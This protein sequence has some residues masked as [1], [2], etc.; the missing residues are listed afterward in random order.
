MF[1]ICLEI[2]AKG[3]FQVSEKERAA[4]IE[5]SFKDIATTV[6]GA[7]LKYSKMSSERHFNFSSRILQTNALIRNQNALTLCP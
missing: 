5:S 7:I 2:L 4:S 3:E 1:Q 6:S